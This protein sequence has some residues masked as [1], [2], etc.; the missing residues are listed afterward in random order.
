MD[1]E[2]EDKMQ[3]KVGRMSTISNQEVDGLKDKA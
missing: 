1:L 2:L 3:L